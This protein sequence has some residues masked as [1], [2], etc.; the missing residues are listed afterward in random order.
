MQYEVR[1]LAKFPNGHDV[2]SV[3]F[4]RRAVTEPLYS[5]EATISPG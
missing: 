2:S 3:E 5:G 1:E 4:F